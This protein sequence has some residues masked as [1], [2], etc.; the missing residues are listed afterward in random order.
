M[1]SIIAILHAIRDLFVN[2]LPFSIRRKK[3]KYSF[4]VHSRDL[5]DVY[6][7]YPFFKFF[8]NKL[9]EFIIFHMWPIV[10]SEVSGL[11]SL[12]NGEEIPGL[13]VA[14]PMTAKQMMEHRELAL[15]KIIKSA[16]FSKKLGAS[17][18]GLGGLTTSL[19]KGGLD[20]IDKVKINI[21]TGHA[22]TAYT[23]TSNVI[24]LVK[25][26]GMDKN[27]IVVA[28]VGATG[29]IGSTSAKIL[30]KEGFA[31][32][33]LIDIERKKH[34]FKNLIEE[35]SSINQKINIETTPKIQEIKKADIIIT[36]TNAPEAV[37][38]NDYLKSGA[39]I[40]DDAQPSDVH[41]E[42][43][44]REDVMAI[45]A[46]VVHTPNIDSHFNFGLKDKYD[47]F[48]CMCEIMILAA[49][50][51]D[52]HYVINRANLKNVDHIVNLS[53]GLGF[54]LAKYQNFKE[55]ISSDK[56]NRIKK[57]INK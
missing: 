45:E 2:I 42:V 29:S 37:V 4:L 5:S 54:R 25:E 34:F 35:V 20:I 18:I 17:I 33:L 44:E 38:R 51:W 43:F 53:K 8:P 21:T 36:A 47:N 39:I 27:F 31:N 50:N 56:I 48:C 16:K 55:V 13:V 24:K 23:V 46:G 9:L 19:S 3:F 12:K 1:K 28:I 7:K 10:V 40:V 30:A 11:K 32:L 49:N 15:K 57:V 14:F 52:E 26:I 22:Y 6:R 41:P